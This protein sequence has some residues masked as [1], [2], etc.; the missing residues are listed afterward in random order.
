MLFGLLH[1][2]YF[3]RG[4]QQLRGHTVDIGQF[5]AHLHKLEQLG[6]GRINLGHGQRHLQG[7]HDGCRFFRALRP[8]DGRVVFDG[9][10]HA[11]GLRKLFRRRREKPRP[12]N[13]VQL[14]FHGG[15][16][17]FG[18]HPPQNRGEQHAALLGAQKG[19]GGGHARLMDQNLKQGHQI[20][21]VDHLTPLLLDFKAN[22]HAAGEA[23][24]S[25]QR[26]AIHGHS[27]VVDRARHEFDPPR[28]VVQGRRNQ[29]R[30]DRKL[31]GPQI[32]LAHLVNGL[33]VGQN[34]NARPAPVDLAW[35]GNVAANGIGEGKITGRLAH[36]HLVVHADMIGCPAH[37]WRKLF[38]GVILRDHCM[39]EA[40]RSIVFALLKILL[41][42]VRQV[43]RIRAILGHSL[44][45]A[46]AVFTIYS[47]NKA[48]RV[49]GDV[50]LAEKH[51]LVPDAPAHI[52]SHIDRPG[53]EVAQGQE[54][55]VKLP[56]KVGPGRVAQREQHICYILAPFHDGLVVFQVRV[57]GL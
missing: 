39:D 10:D 29:R 3:L 8:V 4:I 16:D 22:G 1:G 52:I 28:Q 41:E 53:A 17:H 2:V 42:L 30:R 23:D 33:D 38:L 32:G 57:F 18:L 14:A 43:V 54:S 48:V 35:L 49:L 21:V 51:G 45:R 40:I 56:G 24:R 26:L 13:N 25:K 12:R 15:T 34:R 55:L 20:S 47:I 46:H 50:Q 7:L 19:L 36:Q 11:A 6:D 31:G 27:P 9:Q 5:P 37:P 44:L